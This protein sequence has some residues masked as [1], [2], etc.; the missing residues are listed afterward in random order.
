MKLRIPRVCSSS[1]EAF[2][3]G[4]HGVMLL[5]LKRCNRPD[6]NKKLLWGRIEV[7]EKRRTQPAL[8]VE[9]RRVVPV[10]AAIGPPPFQ[11]ELVAGKRR[12]C[13]DQREA[14]L[15]IWDLG[16]SPISHRVGADYKRLLRQADP[17]IVED[18][19]PRCRYGDMTLMAFI[20][21]DPLLN[22][23]TSFEK[24]DGYTGK[25]SCFLAGMSTRLPLSIARPR[26]SRLRVRR[27]VI[28]SSI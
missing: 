19:F 15:G 5:H 1:L 25:L 11:S 14:L 21:V 17:R 6:L 2:G 26:A 9:L 28:T 13:E 23:S 18:P 20:R 7:P 12:R 4:L 16:D 22:G 8:H 24:T 27:G 10:A 3:G